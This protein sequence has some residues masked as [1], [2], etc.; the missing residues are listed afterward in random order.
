M[1]KVGIR[2][3]HKHGDYGQWELE[4]QDTEYSFE[5]GLE[6]L[7]IAYAV[8]PSSYIA[9]EG[10][11]ESMRGKEGDWFMRTPFYD[12]A[13]KN[14]DKESDL[15]MHLAPLVNIEGAQCLVLGRLSTLIE[16][17]IDYAEKLRT[18]HC[19][20]EWA[21]LLRQ[22][23]KDILGSETMGEVL[24]CLSQIEEQNDF[25][26]KI[27]METVYAHLQKEQASYTSYH[28]NPQGVSFANLSTVRG[29]PFSVVCL[30]GMNEG[31]FGKHEA[32]YEFDLLSE[33]K[34]SKREPKETLL[35]FVRSQ[36]DRLLFL[37]LLL[38]VRSQLFISYVGQNPWHSA[39]K[40]L[41]ALVV[42][43]LCEYVDHLFISHSPCFS[44]L[45]T[46]EHPLQSYDPLYFSKEAASTL[47]HSYVSSSY[48][49]AKVW[50][51]KKL[52]T[53]P[54]YK[55]WEPKEVSI[56]DSETELDLN[57]LFRF[58]GNSTRT[59][60]Q[61]HLGVRFPYSQLQE[62]VWNSEESH[63]LGYLECWQLIDGIL[64]KALLSK[65]EE[66]G[67]EMPVHL[68]QKIK[69][70]LLAIPGAWGELWQKDYW[71]QAKDFVQRLHDI[72][73][74]EY[75][76]LNAPFSIAC[77]H[78]H[79]VRGH[80]G[81]YDA[82]SNSKQALILFRYSK[83]KAEQLLRAW[84]LHL[85]WQ[86]S[87]FDNNDS[88]KNTSQNIVR[89][90]LINRDTAYMFCFSNR[91]Q[92]EEQDISQVEKLC[93]QYLMDLLKIYENAI[94]GPQLVPFFCENSYA[95]AN[96]IFK[97]KKPEEAWRAAV[98]IMNKNFQQSSW[99]EDEYYALCMR[100]ND[101]FSYS[102]REMKLQKNNFKQT[103]RREFA[104][105]S[106]QV[107]QPLLSYSQAL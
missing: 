32:M 58:F 8:P 29:V 1:Q 78:K 5:A 106:E 36:E 23:E 102:E 55:G 74:E 22:M 44:Q 3:G 43:E 57:S 60:I 105:I 49:M 39:K 56:K 25:K 94:S 30:L 38:T 65:N 9:W 73:G 12:I 2:W 71:Q 83:N 59:F 63:E 50:Q 64:I 95:Y 37:E 84:I 98:S 91:G 24:G 51:N 81:M 82:Y 26:Q 7:F 75:E 53:P 31:V 104:I 66:Q 92:N 21:I 35:P 11:Q 99:G 62:Q 88:K 68:Q 10:E 28:S 67:E 97:N 27:G 80:W 13:Q 41:P 6:R 17:F 87:Q 40:H 52:P 101:F 103:M 86:L 77:S 72:I 61:E 45:L 93:R 69:A 18:K 15:Y 19:L 89:T 54:F 90:Y 85:L 33:S 107:F 34:H 96:A 70:K 100:N 48:E 4:L 16:L 47:P 76:E 20:S 46:V 79:Y 14:I 42:Q